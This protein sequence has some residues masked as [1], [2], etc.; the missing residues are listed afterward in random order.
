[1][2]RG[3]RAYRAYAY[4]AHRPG[5]PLPVYKEIDEDGFSAELT[6]V[7]GTI[8]SKSADGEPLSGL[9]VAIKG[10][11]WF[12]KTDD[13]GRFRLGAMPAGDYTLVVWPEKGKPKEKKISVPATDGDYDVEM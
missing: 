1:M 3:R 6:H 12:D 8:R 2:D 11:G 10:K 5:Q 7:G 13:D 4:A 9:E